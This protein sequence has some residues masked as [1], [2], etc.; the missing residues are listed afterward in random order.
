MANKLNSGLAKANAD[1]QLR[2]DAQVHGRRSSIGKRETTSSLSSG[3]QS[4]SSTTTVSGTSSS[5]LS[6]HSNITSNTSSSTSTSSSL[7][8]QRRLN[9]QRNNRLISAAEKVP[10]PIVRKAAQAAKLAKKIKAAKDKKA[11]FLGNLL[12]SKSST[13]SAA[14]LED[15]KGAEDRGEDYEPEDTEGR[16]SASLDRKTKQLFAAFVMGI[17]GICVFLCLITTSAITG[18]AKESYLASHDNPTEEEL[19]QAYAIDAANGS[20]NNSSSSTGTTPGSSFASGGSIKTDSLSNVIMVGDS[21]T[22]MLCLDVYNGSSCETLGYKVGNTTFIAGVGESYVWFHGTALPMLKELL[23]SNPKSTVFINLGTNGFDDADKYAADYNQLAKDYPN[24]NIIAVSVAPV[25][26]AKVDEERDI[27]TDANAV[28]FNNSLKGY[29]SSDVTYCDIYSQLK[30]K[31]DASDGIHYDEASDKLVDEAMKNCLVTSSSNSTGSSFSTLLSNGGTSESELN[32]KN[33]QQLVVVESSGSSANVSFYEKNG[34]NWTNDSGLNASGYVGSNG[35]TSS[36]AEGKSATP[37][38]LYGV[39][40][41]FYQDTKPN[42]KLNIFQITSNTYWV[43]D[44]DSKYYNQKV[45]GTANKDWSSAEHM[46]EIDSYR[47][48]FVI[49]YNMNPVVSGAGSAIFF[50]VSHNSPTA[51]CV[52]VSEDKVLDYLARLDKS[53]N[54]YIL[55]I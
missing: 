14:E 36:P 18:G 24:A 6:S 2:N 21:R 13:P 40:D 3:S 8:A 17:V 35:T 29:L 27:N 11:G 47:Y 23:N 32:Q 41:A 53:K 10:I 49:N 1:K 44:P 25:I 46:S 34:S 9:Q 33:I 37:K 30:G 48:G 45:E 16:Y 22:V 4:S 7:D 20:N 31:V 19:A 15:A 28:K 26:D 55:I 39:G 51:G 38:G 12:G 43:D 52:S 50:H 42:T 5:S 54:P